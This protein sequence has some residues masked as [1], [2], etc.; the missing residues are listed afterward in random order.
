MTRKAAK[1]E[2]DQKQKT[3][4][5]TPEVLRIFNRVRKKYT[6][7]LAAL[8]NDDD[9][10]ET[11]DASLG[12]CQI[13]RAA[14][15]LLD[16]AVDNAEPEEFVRLITRARRKRGP[17]SEKKPPSAELANKDHKAQVDEQLRK[18]A[19]NMATSRVS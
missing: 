9:D 11:F 18:E 17:Q 13:L 5:S 1:G 4:P 14:L 10:N 3:L 6:K 15:L 12:D 7:A 8:I 19:M 2:A 16:D